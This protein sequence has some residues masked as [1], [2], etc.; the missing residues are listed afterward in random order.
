LAL[1]QLLLL[2]HLLLLLLLLLLLASGVAAW[3]LQRQRSTELCC[4]HLDT[5]VLKQGRQVPPK[6]TSAAFKRRCCLLGI[7]C[8]W[9]KLHDYPVACCR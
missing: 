8:I 6:Q 9:L 1:P 3:P 5:Y 2:L 4:Q 7:D